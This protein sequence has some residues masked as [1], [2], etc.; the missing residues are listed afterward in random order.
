MTLAA[1]LRDMAIATAI[2]MGM[3]MDTGT[4]MGMGT[5]IT[6]RNTER[7]IIPHRLNKDQRDFL[8]AF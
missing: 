8:Q 7:G 4:D 6:G 5:G 3:G 1:A 2:I